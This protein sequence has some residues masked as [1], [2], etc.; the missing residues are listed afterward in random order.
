MIEFNPDIHGTGVPVVDE[1]HKRLFEMVNVLVDGRSRDPKQVRELLTFLGEYVETHFREEEQLMADRN[2][3]V[4]EL[5]KLEHR[6]FLETYSRF[7]NRFDEV[8]LTRE[9]TS[10]IRRELVDWLVNHITKIDRQLL[11]TAPSEIEQRSAT[12]L[13]DR[14]AAGKPKSFWARWFG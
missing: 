12:P 7:V 13:A 14:V 5:N 10:D 2:C 9:F 3:P 6:R 1:Q 4:L 8:G 11:E